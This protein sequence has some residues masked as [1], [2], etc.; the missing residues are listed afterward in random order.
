LIG[1][2]KAE[3]ALV[4]IPQGDNPAEGEGSLAKAL[5]YYEELVKNYPK[6]FLAKTAQERI[7]NLGKTAN[8]P[9]REAAEKFYQEMRKLVAEAPKK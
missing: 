1:A 7:D 9:A 2:A 3:E 5:S 8:D 6:S 4:G